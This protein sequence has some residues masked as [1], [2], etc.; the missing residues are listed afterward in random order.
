MDDVRRGIFT[1]LGVFLMGGAL[2]WVLFGFGALTS[3]ERIVP[4]VVFFVVGGILVWLAWRRPHGKERQPMSD[5][6]PQRFNVTNYGTH[7]TAIGQQINR[8]DDPR[9]V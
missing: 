7:G 1:T 4:A 6:E 8:P 5:E 9:E 2:T 3:A